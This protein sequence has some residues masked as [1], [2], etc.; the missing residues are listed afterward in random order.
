MLGF[1]LTLQTTPSKR[2]NID[3]IGSKQY[4]DLYFMCITSKPTHLKMVTFCGHFV[5]LEVF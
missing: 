2:V 4:R 3:V 1:F 5:P